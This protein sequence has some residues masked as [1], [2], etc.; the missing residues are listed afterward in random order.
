MRGNGL[1]L[2]DA[3]ECIREDRNGS[4]GERNAT[5]IT[6]YAMSMN[7][8]LTCYIFPVRQEGLEWIMLYL[9]GLRKPLVGL[10]KM[11]AGTFI[12]WNFEFCFCLLHTFDKFGT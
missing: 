8:H 7:Y 5:I 10:R 9:V 6:G 11:A 12:V 2:N 3:S 1:E 4:T